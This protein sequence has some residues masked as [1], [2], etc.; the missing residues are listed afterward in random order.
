MKTTNRFEGIAKSFHPSAVTRLAQTHVAVIGVGGVGSWCVETLVR[1]G[2]GKITLM[3]LDDI[4]LSNTNRQIHALEGQYGK[5][6]VDA[7][8]ERIHLINPE[9]QVAVIEDFFDENTASEFFENTYDYVID[10]IDSAKNKCLLIAECYHRQIPIITVGGAGA[11]KD[12][13]KIQIADLNKTYNDKLLMRVRKILKRKYQISKGGRN[14]LHI[15]CV[16]SSEVIDL[17][18]NLDEVC[19]LPESELNLANNKLNCQGSLGSLMHITAA[20]GMMAASIV[21]NRVGEQQT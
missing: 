10:C 7:L 15:P 19:D 8:K 21:I 2:V 18:D 16:F 17:P 1:S 20:M 12:P 14:N 6:K 9:C 3:D 13:T 11:R 4:C 5:L